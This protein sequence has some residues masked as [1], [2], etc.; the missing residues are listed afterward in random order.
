MQKSVLFRDR[1]FAAVDNR[2][3]AAGEEVGKPVKIQL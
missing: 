1:R 3:K 2:A